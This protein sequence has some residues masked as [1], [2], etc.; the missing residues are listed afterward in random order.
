[1]S[2]NRNIYN[3][4]SSYNVMN[5]KQPTIKFLNKTGIS[6]TEPLTNFCEEPY[7]NDAH[8][9]S[10]G[11]IT[12]NAS[13]YITVVNPIRNSCN[14]CSYMYPYD[15]KS[16]FDMRG[17]KVILD[18]P[19]QKIH[20]HMD[21][22]SRIDNRA[23]KSFYN[24]YGEMNNANTSYYYDESISQ[25]FYNPVYTLSSTVD[26]TILE[27]P[28]GSRW[29]QYFKNPVLSTNNNVSQDQATRDA[30]SF[31]DDII[32]KQQ[33]LYN[34]TSWTNLNVAPMSSGC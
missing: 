29:P 31:R 8:Y 26:K 4:G 5:N 14:G 20:I 30:L 34:R 12:A 10:M 15:G 6:D 11:H 19:A 3:I 22:V 9:R 28:M 1:M 18:K 32:S 27:T 13:K 24:N 33:S 7:N 16:S 2:L 23:Y 25:P 21:D 17:S